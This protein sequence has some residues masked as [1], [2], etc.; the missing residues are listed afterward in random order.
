MYATSVV[1]SLGHGRVEIINFSFISSIVHLHFMDRKQ[2]NKVCKM[3]APSNLN[4]LIQILCFKWMILF[5]KYEPELKKKQ[6]QNLH[7]RTRDL[8]EKAK[9]QKISLIVCYCIFLILV[10]TEWSYI[11]CFECLVTQITMF[12]SAWIT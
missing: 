10:K 12:I 9:G 5:I 1:A 3:K 11:N 8:K 7:L 2:W 6:K 4:Y